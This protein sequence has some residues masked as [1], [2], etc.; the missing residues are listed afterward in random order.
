MYLLREFLLNN[1]NLNKHLV[2]INRVRP[3]IIFAMTYLTYSIKSFQLMSRLKLLNTRKLYCVDNSY[4]LFVILTYRN[5]CNLHV[6]P[7]MSPYLEL[8]GCKK[9]GRVAYILAH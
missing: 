1:H 9:L 3:K 2:R 7:M 4:Y 8:K 6:C 5:R